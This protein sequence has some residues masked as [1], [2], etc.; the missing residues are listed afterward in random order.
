MESRGKDSLFVAERWISV[1]EVQQYSVCYRA[2]DVCC[3]TVVQQYSVCCRAMDVCCSSTVVQYVVLCLL[4]SDGCLLQQYS[5]TVSTVLCTYSEN[6]TDYSNSTWY[7]AHYT[8]LQNS[9]Y[10][11]GK[12]ILSIHDHVIHNRALQKT[13]DIFHCLVVFFF[14]KCGEQSKKH[15][16][17]RRNFSD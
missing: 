7:S 15:C 12:R 10:A 9:Y 13:T 8:Q 11:V 16:V 4:Q 6:I 1:A 3:S 2:M 5:S 17:G 14:S